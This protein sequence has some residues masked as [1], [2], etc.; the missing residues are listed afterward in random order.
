MIERK[1]QFTI[2]TFFAALMLLAACNSPAPPPQTPTFP[3]QPPTIATAT[4]T[5]E[6]DLENTTWV[7]KELNGSSPLEN[8][9][10]T[11]EFGSGE[12]GGFAGCNAYGSSDVTAES[13]VLSIKTIEIT[14][15]ACLEPPGVLE[16]ESA[17]VQALQNAAVYRVEKEALSIDDSEGNTILVLKRKEQFVI[18]PAD[19][20]GTAWQLVSMNG[21]SLLE[22]STI[23]L[24]FFDEDQATGNAG[25]RDYI[26]SYEPVEDSI[27][28]TQMIMIGDD[29]PDYEALMVQEGDYTTMLGWTESLKMDQ[30]RLEIMTG[31]GGLLIFEPYQPVEAEPP[32]SPL[33]TMSP[34]SYPGPESPLPTPQSG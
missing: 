2:I 25:C 11:L 26:A 13:G 1:Y 21:S 28:F 22:N 15:Q 23:T 18:D 30:N 34:G 7:L 10:I 24:E 33:P 17:F 19:L 31:R 29:C 8:S 32:I 20:P 27:Q 3:S 6:I 16:Q 5:G 4:I 12:I 9:W 14:L